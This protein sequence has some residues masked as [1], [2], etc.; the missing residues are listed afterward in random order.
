MQTL[1]WNTSRES[2]K[3]KPHQRAGMRW[4]AGANHRS[5]FL[6]PGLG[7]TSI[8]LAVF[9]ALQK[10]GACAKMLVIAPLRPAQLVWSQNEGCEIARWKEFEHFKVV[11]LHGPKKDKRIEQDA[12]IYVINF[13]GLAWL[14]ENGH[15]KDLSKRG[16][17]TACIDELSKFKHPSSKRF[18]LWKKE[19]GRFTR[20]WGLTGTPAS[21]GLI[22][23]FGQMYAVDAGAS[24]G[25]WITSYR[26]EYFNPTGYGGYTWVLQKGADKRIYKA[27]SKVAL[28]MRAEDH[29]KL[30]PL[31]EQNVWVTLPSKARKTYDQFEADMYAT[32]DGE[33]VTAA[34]AAVVSMKCQQISSG[35]IYASDD[36]EALIKSAKYRKAHHI[37][38]EKTKALIELIDELQGQ[39]LLVAYGFEHDLRRIRAE[40]GKDIPVLGGGVSEKRAASIVNAWNRGEIPVLC[41]HPA[42]VGHGLNMQKNSANHLAWYSMTWNLELYDQFT[43]RIWRQGTK[44]D[45]IFAH[46]IVARD[47]VDEVILAT[48]RRKQRT[49][50]D[51]MQALRA[52]RDRKG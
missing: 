20:R 44:A 31:I 49:Q 50:K 5:L 9:K 22:D 10:S 39:S 18:K 19:L 47:T 32:L 26:R 16:V 14:I 51:L 46:R 25:P 52:R 6:D 23:L 36:S 7:K 42:S 4:L 33:V 13:E 34:N 45:K 40:L 15:L 3:P 1:H 35:G 21:N 2:W 48:L 12:D 27:I 38:D 28:S 24:L 37:H 41:A 29:L 11:L 43:K 17:D 30:P 8:A